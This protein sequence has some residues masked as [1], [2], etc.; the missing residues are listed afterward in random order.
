MAQFG[1]LTSLTS[2]KGLFHGRDGIDGI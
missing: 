2:S 1:E